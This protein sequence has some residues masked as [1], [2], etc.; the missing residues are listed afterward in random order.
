MGAS[1]LRAPANW[2]PDP[3]GEAELRY[4]DGDEWT[5]T[6][7]KHGHVGEGPMRPEAVAAAWQEERDGRVAWPRRVILVGAAGAA[8]AIGLALVMRF[9]A[10][11]VW[12]GSGFA[13]LVAG[14]AGLWTGLLM[15]C[16]W[17]SRRYGTGRVADDYGF[18]VRRS[19]I[20]V[21]IGLAA[22]ARLLVF[23]AV[24]PLVLLLD[25]PVMRNLSPLGDGAAG[26]GALVLV[27][28]LV[29]G[30]PVVEE[31]FFRG[32]LQRSL[33]AALPAAWA[34]VVQAVVFG[35]AHLDG[36]LGLANVVVF[37]ST[38]IGG[39]VFGIAARSTRRLGPAVAAHASFNVL[40]AVLLLAA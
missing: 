38:A 4:W 12:T 13:E 33:E 29:L 30:A 2:Y 40:P 9:A 22:V 37:V 8:V 31:L 18:R 21:G 35:A 25:Q 15:S 11:A 23:V 5:A 26:A 7:V 28:V 36:E 16:W 24:V 14:T 39:V 10:G 20:P 17:A 6:V 3:T 1:G 19:D 34:I 32:L 27:A